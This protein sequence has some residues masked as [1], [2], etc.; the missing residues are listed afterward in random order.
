MMDVCPI[1]H[2]KHGHTKS[3]KVTSVAIASND[4][5]KAKAINNCKGMKQAEIQP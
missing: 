1:L 4:E 5:N 3:Q 2:S